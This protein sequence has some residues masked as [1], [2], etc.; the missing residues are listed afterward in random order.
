MLVDVEEH[1][2]GD[3]TDPTRLQHTMHLG[4]RAQRVGDV[5]EGV[6]TDHTADTVVGEREP[7]HVFGPIDVRPVEQV[8]ADEDATWEYVAKQRPLLLVHRGT[9]A[10]LDDRLGEIEALG[11][12]GDEVVD[13][14]AHLP[15][16]GLGLGIGH[17]R[18]TGM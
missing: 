4:Y 16:L 7:L 9:R 12:V 11:N 17:A 3:G 18:A 10:D 8:A 2:R 14:R 5:F 1:H 15:S 6:H 13:D